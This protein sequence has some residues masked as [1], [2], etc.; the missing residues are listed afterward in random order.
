MENFPDFIKYMEKGNRELICEWLMSIIELR[1][2][3]ILKPGTSQEDTERIR[4]EVFSLLF[5]KDA[6]GLEHERSRKE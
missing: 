2:Q 4:G 6:F 3:L 1:T 5:I